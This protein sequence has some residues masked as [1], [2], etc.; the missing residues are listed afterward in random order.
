[1]REIRAA[2]DDGVVRAGAERKRR[3]ERSG[4]WLSTPQLRDRE[5][6][7]PDSPFPALALPAGSCGLNRTI[8]SSAPNRAQTG[9]LPRAALVPNSDGS[10]NLA[11]IERLRPADG[12]LSACVQRVIHREHPRILYGEADLVGDCVVPGAQGVTGRTPVGACVTESVV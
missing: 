5:V 9:A 6:H 4:A 3:G 8:R 12:A 1:M 7:R 10:S 11:A 2:V